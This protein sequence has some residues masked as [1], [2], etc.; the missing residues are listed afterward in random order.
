MEIMENLNELEDILNATYDQ[1]AY[2]KITLKFGLGV[3]INIENKKI[4]IT[5]PRLEIGMLK[6]ILRGRLCREE[7]EQKIYYEGVRNEETELAF[8]TFYGHNFV[9]KAKEIETCEFIRENQASG[10]Y[11]HEVISR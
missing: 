5:Y 2:L 1:D 4:T 8:E 6:H 7:G 11:Y 10:P 3:D 9:L